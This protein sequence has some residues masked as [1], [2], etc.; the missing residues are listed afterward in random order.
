VILFV[1]E[2]MGRYVVPEA[3]RA[4]G[5]QAEAHRDHFPPG[6]PDADWIEDVTKRG[7]VIVGKDKGH[8]F[9]PLEMLAIQR[10]GARMFTLASG[11]RTGVENAEAIVKALRAMERFDATHAPP[12]IARITR[13]GAVEAIYAPSSR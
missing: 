7:W 5:V 1:D 4:A 2:G 11:K 12:Y 13:A 6:T 9:E 3:I 8:R 10:S